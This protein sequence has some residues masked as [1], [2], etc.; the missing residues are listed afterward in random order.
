MWWIRIN[1]ELIKDI[2]LEGMQIIKVNQLNTCSK[3]NG[4]MK[5]SRGTASRN[6]LYVGFKEFILL[7]CTASKS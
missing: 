6:L 7:R 1:Q 4:T 3:I 5:S 2:K